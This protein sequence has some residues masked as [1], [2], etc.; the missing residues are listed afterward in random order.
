[1]KQL[2]GLLCMTLLAS[3]GFAQDTWKYNCEAKVYVTNVPVTVPL[4]KIQNQ[5]LG[6][7]FDQELGEIGFTIG[8]KN[9]FPS[10]YIA[11]HATGAYAKTSIF[12][13]QGELFL[14][15]K[16]GSAILKCV[17]K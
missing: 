12:G 6:Q 7:F 8:T 10:L 15:L 13:D 11:A 1:M 4:K 17:T 5:L 3:T 14:W 9:E 2:I 16:K